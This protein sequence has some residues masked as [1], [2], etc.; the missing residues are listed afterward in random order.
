MGVKR[1]V[2]SIS[3]HSCWSYLSHELLLDHKGIGALCA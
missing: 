2:P 1:D 3:T